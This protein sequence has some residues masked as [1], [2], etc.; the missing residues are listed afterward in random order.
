VAI[1]GGQ[2]KLHLPNATHAYSHW[3]MNFIPTLGEV[4]SIQ[5]NVIKCLSWRSSSV[6]SLIKLTILIKLKYFWKWC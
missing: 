6:S 4:Y 2:L 1:I 3:S 5:L